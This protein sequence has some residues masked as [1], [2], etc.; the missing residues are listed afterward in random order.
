MAGQKLCL[1]FLAVC[2][3]GKNHQ[4]QRNAIVLPPSMHSWHQDSACHQAMR[5]LGSMRAVFPSHPRRQNWSWV[6]TIQNIFN[7]HAW[8]IVLTSLYPSCDVSGSCISLSKAFL[9]LKRKL[10]LDVFLSWHVFLKM[11]KTDQVA[12][13]I[14]PFLTPVPSLVSWFDISWTSASFRPWNSSNSFGTYPGWLWF[15]DRKLTQNSWSPTKSPGSN[16][17]PKK[18]VK[19]CLINGHC[20]MNPP[21]HLGVFPNFCGTCRKCGSHGDPA[22]AGRSMV[23]LN[24]TVPQSG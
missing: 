15:G 12:F 4:S 17:C 19:I 22:V 20:L 1:F 10:S 6:C 13:D 16:L 2:H 11:S 5:Q 7:V 18:C 23:S 8:H 3:E 9:S 14:H 24:S 21:L